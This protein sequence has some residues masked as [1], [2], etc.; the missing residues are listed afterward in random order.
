MRQSDNPNRPIPD[1]SEESDREGTSARR[2]AIN[3]ISNW[4]AMGAQVFALMFLLSYVYKKFEVRYGVDEV[5]D[6]WGVYRLSTYFTMA[7]MFLSFGMAGSV[8]R[9]ASESVAMR[10]GVRLSQISSVSRTVLLVS[11]AVGFA[12]VVSLTLLGLEV[13]NIPD[14]D[15]CRGYK[16]S[17]AGGGGIGDWVG[18]NPLSQRLA[19]DAALRPGERRLDRRIHSARRHRR[20]LF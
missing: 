6:L 2:V 3:T 13:F 4:V 11:A 19:G 9:L 1:V 7:V 18:S 10:D 8:I 14:G 17:S 5:R 20:S 16:A 12:V 15:A